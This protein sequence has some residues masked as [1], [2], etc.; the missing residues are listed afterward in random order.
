M[1]T[2]RAGECAPDRGSVPSRR[3]SGLA[4]ADAMGRSEA[5]PR[6]PSDSGSNH[7]LPCGGAFAYPFSTRGRLDEVATKAISIP[8]CHFD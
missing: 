7:Q 4:G 2:S 6:E 3:W 5:G 1:A 8:P